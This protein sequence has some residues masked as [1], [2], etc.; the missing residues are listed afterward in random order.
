LFQKNGLSSKEDTSL[1]LSGTWKFL[2]SSAGSRTSEGCVVFRV[3][4]QA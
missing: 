3:G 2:A 1:R 4:L